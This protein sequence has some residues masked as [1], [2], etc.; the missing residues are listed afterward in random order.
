MKVKD[1]A[2]AVAVL[3]RVPDMRSASSGERRESLVELARAYAVSDKPE[4]LE[5]A[6]KYAYRAS[7][8]DAAN[9]STRLLQAKILLKT[10][11]LTDRDRAIELLRALTAS[12]LDA[13]ISSDAHNSLGL[14]YYKNGD[15]SRALGSFDYAVQLN[16]SN[17][18]AYSNQRLAANA[19]EQSL[20]Q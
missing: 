18:E 10:E 4:N 16:P 14:A 5:T 6:K 7:Q 11:S 8:L 2:S 20:K 12:D 9:P 1:Y 19:L 15:Y 17:K 3:G 13:K